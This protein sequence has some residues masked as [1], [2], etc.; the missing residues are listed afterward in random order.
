MVFV[1][2]TAARPSTNVPIGD[3]FLMSTPANGRGSAEPPCLE[4]LSLVCGRQAS[5]EPG[6]VLKRERHH[7]GVSGG[8]VGATERQ[9]GWTDLCSVEKGR[10]KGLILERTS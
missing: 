7:R 3:A 4:E 6:D 8:V 2:T 1:P 5:T 10:A 9:D